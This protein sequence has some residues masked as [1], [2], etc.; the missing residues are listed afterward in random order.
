MVQVDGNL[1]QIH[2]RLL[3][4]GRA[5]HYRRNTFKGSIVIV[6]SVCTGKSGTRNGSMRSDF[7]HIKLRDRMCI[8]YMIYYVKTCSSLINSDLTGH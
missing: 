3:P 4:V 8:M 5:V 2:D 7:E 6:S 1:G